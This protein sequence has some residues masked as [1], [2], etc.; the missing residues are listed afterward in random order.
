MELEASC[1]RLESGAIGD[2]RVRVLLALEPELSV[3]QFEFVSGAAK[4]S[5]LVEQQSLEQAEKCQGD[6]G[7]G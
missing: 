2:D 7:Q 4:N 6:D 1:G 3:G 5:G